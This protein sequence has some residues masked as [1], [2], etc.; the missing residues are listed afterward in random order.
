MFKLFKKKRKQSTFIYCMECK[1]ELV[2]ND[3][4]ISDDDGIVT[5]KCSKCGRVG[6][7]DFIH[8]PVPLLIK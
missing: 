2:S 3:S 4:F 5:Y 6:R 1:N 7:Y 8:Y